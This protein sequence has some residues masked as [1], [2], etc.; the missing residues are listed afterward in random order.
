MAVL[1][2]L[3]SPFSTLLPSLEASGFLAAAPQ[4]QYYF[5]ILD[6]DQNG[7][8]PYNDKSS[9][10]VLFSWNQMSCLQAICMSRYKEVASYYSLLSLLAS[11]VKI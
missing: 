8:K 10:D 2:S 7:R 1:D 3:A 4:N 11:K 9:N 5:R 6:G